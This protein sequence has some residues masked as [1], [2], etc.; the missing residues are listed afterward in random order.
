LNI[1]EF[2]VSLGI[3]GA[4][5]AVGAVKSVTDSMS[6]LWETSTGAKIA[7]VG[8]FYELEQMFA[9]ANKNAAELSEY[10]TLT[11]NSTLKVQEY[12]AAIQLATGKQRDLNTTLTTFYDLQTK[13]N[14]IRFNKGGIVGHLQMMFSSLGMQ[15]PDPRE[16]QRWA[17]NVDMLAQHMR[18]FADNAKRRHMEPGMIRKVLEGITGDEDFISSLMTG[19]LSPKKLDAML[20][21]TLSDNYIKAGKKGAEAWAKMHLE[22][23]NAMGKF[24][25]IDGQKLAN[26]LEPLVNVLLK[27]SLALADIADKVK[28]F[29]VIGLAISGWAL[30]L[31]NINDAFDEKD[32][33]IAK[34]VALENKIA[35][36]Q[37]ANDW[38]IRQLH[39]PH[40][41]HF[42]IEQGGP[43]AEVHQL[44]QEYITTI[45]IHT[46]SHDPKEHGKQAAKS[47]NEGIATA[48]AN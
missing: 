1:A 22:M 11:G 15:A 36:N 48:H 14:D 2:F 39:D 26:D 21:L 42:T 25:A 12:N 18:E 6:N 17:S 8:A 23:D 19:G 5:G 10:G 20:P 45:N 44:K 40:R 24:N 37:R 13:I 47:F 33:G 46:P 3:K 35:A 16:L 9:G 34:M 32:R 30:I 7:I 31:N 29:K 27:L 38:I 43:V 4:E 41:K 28:V